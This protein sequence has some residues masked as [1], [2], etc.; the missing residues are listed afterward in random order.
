MVSL[1]SLLFIC[2]MRKQLT[3]STA[4]PQSQAPTTEAPKP[5]SVDVRKGTW[6]AVEFRILLR[7]VFLL[8][9]SDAT[10]SAK[11]TE[12]LKETLVPVLKVQR[13]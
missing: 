1:F 10:Q 13:K 5:A 4:I 8:Q 11:A 3:I 12:A 6:Q 2:R 9:Y 7:K